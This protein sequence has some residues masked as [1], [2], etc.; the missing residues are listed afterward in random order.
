MKPMAQLMQDLQQ[1]QRSLNTQCDATPVDCPL[2][3]DRGL[4]LA[5]RDGEWYARPCQC[6]EKK[7]LERMIQASGLGDEERSVRLGD[8]KPDIF[9]ATMLRVVQKYLEEFPE[10]YQSRAIAKGLALTGHVGAGKTMLSLAVANE[11]LER[12][13]PVV[14]V[15][16]PAL[17]GELRAAQF[18]DGGQA[19]EN[20]VNALSTVEVAIFDDV[21]QEK[22]SE[23][24]QT[25][26]FRIVDNRYR[27]RLPTIFNSNHNFDEIAARL[28]DAVLSRLYAMTKGRQ[29]WCQG[30]DYRL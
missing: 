11:L 15:V 29:V 23:W 19:L 10:I 7:A 5:K 9:T 6:I 1:A 4:V 21:A 17:I 27:H 16:T 13:I 22:V 14:F 3:N 28:G 8:F 2:C 26:Y 12:R 30:A 25:Q 20:K 24:V 18:T